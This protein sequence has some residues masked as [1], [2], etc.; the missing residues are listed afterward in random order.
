IAE[1]INRRLIR[2]ILSGARCV[3]L[4]SVAQG[5]VSHQTF[6]TQDVSPEGTTEPSSPI[7]ATGNEKAHQGSGKIA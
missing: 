7:E 1:Q 4:L 3:P 6:F 2:R 5:R